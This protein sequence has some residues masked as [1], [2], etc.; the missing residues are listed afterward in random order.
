MATN[1]SPAA[2]GGGGG[3]RPASRRPSA[4]TFGTTFSTS[5]PVS[6]SAAASLRRIP[7][8]PLNSP[9]DLSHPQ[10]QQQYSSVEYSTSPPKPEIYSRGKHISR[11][12]S[13]AQA[14]VAGKVVVAGSPSG[15]AGSGVSGLVGGAEATRRP[16][17]DSDSSSN[18]ARSIS[19]ASGA[20]AGGPASGGP[21]VDSHRENRRLPAA[22]SPIPAMHWSKLPK[23]GEAPSPLR[24]H[25]MTLVGHRLFVFGGCD[26]RACYRDLYV[27]DTEALYWSKAKTKGTIPEPCRAHS[28]VLL[29]RKLYVFGGGDGPIYFSTLHCLDTETFVW[30]KLDVAGGPG[31]RR[32]HT[33]WPYDGNIYV[34]AGGDGVRAISDIFVLNTREGLL[35][36]SLSGSP[37]PPALDTPPVSGGMVGASPGPNLS[38]TKATT[39]GPAPSPRGYHTSTLIQGGKKVVVF[40][41]SDGN[42]CFS[43]VHVLDLTDMK[44]HAVEVDKPYPRL[45]HTA[46][47]VGSYLFIFGGHDGGKYSNEVL[48]LNLVTM[49]WEARRCFG[50][51]PRGRGYHTAVLC[52]SRIFVFGGYDGAEVFDDLWVLDLSACAYL[53]Q[54]TA[55][56]VAVDP[57]I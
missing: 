11:S 20:A 39:T 50:G 42:E 28:T 51:P 8:A 52:D 35:S 22:F 3:V 49:N 13:W 26:S 53:P 57:E 44:W 29:D 4:P 46:T 10:Q 47:Q 43:D 12:K 41:G 23:R 56:D 55:F 37:Q 40:G 16:T 19:S 18:R 1:S 21:I 54:I 33:T 9:Q 17:F 27:F 32:A 24:A 30:T 34:Y 14:P 15:S 38:W 25:T 48:L 2:A 36:N 45:S 7:P 31:P 6:T 5:R